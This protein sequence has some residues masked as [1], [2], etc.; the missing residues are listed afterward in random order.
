MIFNFFVTC[1]IWKAEVLITINTDSIFRVVSELK[2]ILLVGN[3][4][5]HNHFKLSQIIE[6]FVD[7]QFTLNFVFTFAIQS[8][9][10]ATDI[11]KTVFVK[12]VYHKQFQVEPYV[13]LDGEVRLALML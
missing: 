1:S 2:P 12:S 8:L 4:C 5:F 7:I 10:F 9:Q 6:Y 11:P 13:E 3:R